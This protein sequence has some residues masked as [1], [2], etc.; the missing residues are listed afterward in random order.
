MQL[1]GEY[2]APRGGLW[3]ALG[4][5][6][7]AGCAALRPLDNGACEL[8]RVFVR[9]AWRGHGT[10]RRLVQHAI[11]AARRAGYAELRLET[12]GRMRAASA[13]YSALGFQPAP[14]TNDGGNDDVHAMTLALTR[15]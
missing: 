2:A 10:G 11:D 6:Q 4:E 13:L 8:R 7:I 14:R 15:V 3:L 9:P 1:P 12:L 5:T